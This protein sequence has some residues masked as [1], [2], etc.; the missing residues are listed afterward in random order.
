MTPEHIWS[1]PFPKTPPLNISAELS[2]HEPAGT[3]FSPN[4]KKTQAQGESISDLEA[5]VLGRREVDSPGHGPGFE[6]DK[7]CVMYIEKGQ[8]YHERITL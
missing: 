6:A 1:N 4:W 3:I 5:Y 7:Y 2:T 8:M